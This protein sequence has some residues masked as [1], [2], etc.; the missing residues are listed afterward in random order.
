MQH[1]ATHVFLVCIVMCFL[2]CRLF[3]AVHVYVCDNDTAHRHTEFLYVQDI[4]STYFFYFFWIFCT[5][6]ICIQFCAYSDLYK[7]FP[8]VLVQVHME[9]TSNKSLCVFY[10]CTYIICCAFSTQAHIECNH[11]NLLHIIYVRVHNTLFH[12]LCVQIYNTL[13]IFYTG[14]YRMQSCKSLC[15]FYTYKYIILLCIF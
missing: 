4:H 14:T 2:Q 10:V 3:S 8:Y 1:T 6:R 12:I 15:I 11:T 7:G 9:Y 13:C 5:Y